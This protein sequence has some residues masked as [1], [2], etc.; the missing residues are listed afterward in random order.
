MKILIKNAHDKLLAF[1]LEAYIRG[2]VM[3]KEH[4]ILSILVKLVV[5]ISQYGHIMIVFQFKDIL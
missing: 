1:I 5:G 3:R 4:M 2:M